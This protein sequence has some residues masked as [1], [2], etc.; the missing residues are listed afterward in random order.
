MSHR[1]WT[2]LVMSALLG[3]LLSADS[4]RAVP[5]A[6]GIRNTSGSLYE[7]VLNESADKVVIRRDGGNE[8]TFNNVAAGRQPFDLGAFSTYEIEVTKNAPVGYTLISDTANAYTNYDRPTALAINTNPASDYFGTVYISNNNTS[9]AGAIARPMGDG[10]YSM[11][12]DLIGVDLSTSDWT[13]PS[14]DDITQAKAPGFTVTGS[15]NSPWKMT[16]D[17]AGNLIISDWSD[18]NGGIKYAS[19]DLTTGGLVLATEGGPTYGVFSGVSDEFGPIPLHGSIVSTPHVTGSLGVDLTVWALD[20]DVDSGFFSD[21]DPTLGYRNNLWRWD[22]GAAT[23][24]NIPPTLILDP[25]DLSRNSDNSEVFINLGAVADALYDPSKDQWVLTQNRNDGLESGLSVVSIDGAGVPTVEWSSKQFSLD[26]GLDGFADDPTLPTLDGIQ[27]IFRN[28]GSATLS[29]DGTKLFVS[30]VSVPGATNIFMGTES[31]LNGKI[32]VIDLD[33]NGLPALSVDDNGTPGDPSDDIILGIQT[34]VTEGQTSTAFA[35]AVKLDAAGNLYATNNISEQLDV[36]SPG[37]NSKAITTS[38]GTFSVEFI[39]VVGLAGDYNGD[40]VVDAADYTL[41]RDT[42]GDTVT[43]GTGADGN[44]NGVIDDG[45]YNL[46]R[47]NYGMTSLA[48]AAESANVPEPT[49]LLLA[50][51]A[52]QALAVRRSPRASC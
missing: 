40:L 32:L 8:L 24:Y 27:D 48:P 23:D 19:P 17:D 2:L 28:I 38:A 42:L 52:L 4:A 14:A 50:A 37:G 18:G 10:I 20:E 33:A 22:V 44:N 29:P 43:S 15:S 5:Y 49:A 46:W 7:F 1:N 34:I 6:S 31:N 41:W 11:T 13:V 51:F 45:D 35:H 21:P 16:M 30:R 12:A 9:T 26:N 47:T 36:F 25:S 39:E 3:G